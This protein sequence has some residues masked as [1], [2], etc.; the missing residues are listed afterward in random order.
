MIEKL[1]PGCFASAS[2]Y[3]AT[4]RICGKCPINVDCGVEVGK[5]LRAYSAK[6]DVSDF[7]EQHESQEAEKRKA[8]PVT[9]T[10]K[11]KR[12]T[13]PV[14]VKRIFTEREQAILDSVTS[15]KPKNELRKLIE[16][17]FCADLQSTLQARQNP[18]PYDGK[19]YL[20]VAHAMLLEGGF[21]KASL[22][23]RYMT[24]LGWVQ[25]TAFPHVAM[26]CSILTALG[27]A[28]ET[29]SGF[30]LSPTSNQ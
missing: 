17:G 4:S 15:V 28:E 24:Q 3:S 2:N 26:A 21:T 19:R 22:R 14:Q 13:K 7:L 9:I 30:V 12:E 29:K 18:F 27:I 20:H 1:N 25:N 6:A 11:P 10:V 8:Q 16:A 5:K 23:E